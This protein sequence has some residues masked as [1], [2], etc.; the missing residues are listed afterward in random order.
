MIE[1]KEIVTYAEE[2]LKDSID[3]LVDITITPGNII[4]VEIDNDE[5]VDLDRCISLSRYIES[6]LDREIED[7]ELTVGSSGLTSPFKIKRQYKKHIGK[8]VEVLTKNGMKQSG[9]LTTADNDGFSIEIAKMVKHEGAKRKV[10]IKEV[11]SYDYEEIK[12]TKY[13]I[14]F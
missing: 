9:V 12:Y 1:K 6:K 2:F 10:E 4:S 7:F 13:K 5:G 8:E 11:H 3:Y 14:I